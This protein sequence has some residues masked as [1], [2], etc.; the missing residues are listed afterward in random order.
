MS[1]RQPVRR[2]AKRAL[3]PSRPIASDS[4]SSGTTTV[5]CFDS[6]STS[7]SRKGVGDL[8]DLQLEQLA[9]QLRRAARH[10]DRGALRLRGDLGDDGLDALAVV[11]AL[12]VDLLRL[13]QERLDPLAQLHERVAGVVLLDDAGDQ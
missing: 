6:S 5:A 8:R 13:R 10:D 11:V 4:W 1:I 3:R 12:L 9:D 7:T 2:A